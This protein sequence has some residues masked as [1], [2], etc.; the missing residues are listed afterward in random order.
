MYFARGFAVWLVIVFVESVHGTLWQMFLAPAV[1]DFTA[2][3]IAFFTG[4]LLIFLIAYLMVRWIAAPTTGT[5]FAVG[6]M[7]VGLTL[8]FEFGIGYFVLGYTSK[9]LLE[10]YDITR[11]GLMAFGI[12]LMAFVP[13]LAVKARGPGLESNP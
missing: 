7:W 1:G 4:M 12:V 6:V 2:R 11:G 5:L 13:Y 8:A 9:R 3:R 10:D